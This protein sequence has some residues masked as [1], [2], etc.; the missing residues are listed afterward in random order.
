M[1]HLRTAS[2]LLLL[3]TL[4]SQAHKLVEWKARGQVFN[5]TGA[6]LML[7]MLGLVANAYRSRAVLLVC[8]LGFG[9]FA[10]VL[11]CSA[12]WLWRPWPV[13]PGGE[14][15]SDGLGLP[16]GAVGLVAIYLAAVYMIGLRDKP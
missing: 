9:Y 10:Q 11:G 5:V 6:I 12:A 1:T 13:T 3:G 15:C 4:H 7:V 2:L 8:A 16:L 14:L